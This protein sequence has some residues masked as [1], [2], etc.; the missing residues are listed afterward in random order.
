MRYKLTI[1][2]FPDRLREMRKKY[3]IT[4]T[5][6]SIAMSK[7]EKIT[8]KVRDKT[9]KKDKAAETDEAL[10]LRVSIKTIQ[11]WENPPVNGTWTGP[12]IEHVISLCN[13]FDCDFEYLFGGIP[14][15]KRAVADIEAETGLSELAVSSLLSAA[16]ASRQGPLDRHKVDY[17]PDGLRRYEI[18]RHAK[19]RFLEALLIHV[20]LW[21][22]LAAHAFDYYRQNQ[23]D[24][25]FGDVGSLLNPYSGGTP[26]KRLAQ[27][28][29]IQ[30]ERTLSKLVEALKWNALGWFEKGK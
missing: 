10:S 1:D 22:E 3:G 23:I 17:C 11:A 12:R 26:P 18:G 25:M 5:E 15:T 9:G 6:L 14:E 20:D 21:E 30:A 16:A 2:G 27:L 7:G 4:Q 8:P 24:K 13:V 29:A 28:A 19:L